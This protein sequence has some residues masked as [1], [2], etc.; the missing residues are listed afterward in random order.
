MTAVA[1][2]HWSCFEAHGL[3][4]DEVF[5]ALAMEH[6]G[7]RSAG[8]RSQIGTRPEYEV[9]Y[10]REGKPFIHCT[11]GK[12]QAEAIACDVA[13][14]LGTKR[15]W[16]T[17]VMTG[18][19]RVSRP[20]V[21]DDVQVRPIEDLR[22]LPVSSMPGGLSELP[23]QPS[24]NAALVDFGYTGAEDGFINM[25]RLQ[26]AMRDVCNLLTLTTL[27]PMTRLFGEEHWVGVWDPASSEIRNARLSGGFSHPE[28]GLK[29]ELPVPPQSGRMDTIDHARFTA[30]ALDLLDDGEQRIISTFPELLCRLHALKHP[31]R[32]MAQVALEWHARG[33]RASTADEAVVAYT[34]A[35][36]ALLPPST[37]GKCSECKA[38]KHDI[39]KRVDRLLD[40]Y[41]G[42]VMRAEFRKVVYRQRSQIVH[43]ALL[44]DIYEPMMSV[45]RR[46]HLDV[47]CVQGSVRPALLNWLLNAPS[48][49]LPTSDT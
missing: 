34:T 6:G 19:F 44:Y 5:S 31:Q 32:R 27:R 49:G 4:P 35:I 28:V 36:E 14:R 11:A 39:S 26:S 41:A 17:T 2:N 15:R 7:Y 42:A 45:G 10:S 25:L 46:S 3:D 33:H 13:E 23:H 30:G 22:A 18:H 24:L 21:C 38:P 43:G 16:F 40:E 29:D 8:R 47:L 20:F 12:R 48:D 37:S 1:D 9:G